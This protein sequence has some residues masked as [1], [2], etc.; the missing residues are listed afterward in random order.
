MVPEAVNAESGAF[1]FHP[2][3]PA[4]A[5]TFMDRKLA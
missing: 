3:P 1:L 5:A 2:A 4:L